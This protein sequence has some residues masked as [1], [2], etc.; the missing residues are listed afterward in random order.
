[1]FE[2]SM[3]ILLQLLERSTVCFCLK[4]TVRARVIAGADSTPC[5]E[6]F[7]IDLLLKE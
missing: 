4:S 6:C 2:Q 5:L 1:M 7:D 3:K